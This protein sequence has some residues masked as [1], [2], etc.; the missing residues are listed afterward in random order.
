VGAR[1]TIPTT[2]NFRSAD[3]PANDTEFDGDLSSPR[4]K[5]LRGRK[6]QGFKKVGAT[7]RLFDTDRSST[8]GAWGVKG[9]VTGL[10]DVKIKVTRKRLHNGNVCGSDSV[11]LTAGPKRY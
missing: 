11:I 9:N 8:H 1:S 4:G 6:V 3:G 7:F 2:L 5:C 10:P